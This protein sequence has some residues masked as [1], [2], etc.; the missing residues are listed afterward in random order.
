VGI[1]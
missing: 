1:C